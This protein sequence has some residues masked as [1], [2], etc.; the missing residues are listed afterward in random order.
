MTVSR[1]DI[2]AF[3]DGEL[4]VEQE[5][6]IAAAIAADPDLQG[7]VEAH[8]ALKERL[9]GHFAPI[10][11]E[12]VPD[13]L[14]ALLVPKQAE[15]VDFSAAKRRSTTSR[16]IP[17]WGWVAGPALAASLA[18][19]V[20]LP[21]SGTP[22][23]YADEQLARVLDTRLVAEQVQDADTRILLSFRNYQGDFCRAFSNT[24]ASGIACRDAEGWKLEALG[25]ARD[26]AGTDYRMAG[27]SE[28]DLLARA[29][30]M[31]DGPA[32]DAAAEAQARE[33]GWLVAQ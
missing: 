13:A 17:R 22:D 33:N 1:E 8:R 15:V 6:Q 21:R 31:A 20:F 14:A 9:S 25:K 23:G 11:E 4:S 5:G 16:A 28:G 24:E 10:A 3:V 18:L 30:Q 12:P 2:A 19:A 27:A 26:E 29:Q 32:L 7:Q